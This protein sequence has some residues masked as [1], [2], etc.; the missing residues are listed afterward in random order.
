MTYRDEV[1]DETWNWLGVNES[2][3]IPNPIEK[4]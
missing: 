1:E 2:I 4:S 3:D